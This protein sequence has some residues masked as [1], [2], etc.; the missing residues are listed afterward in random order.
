MDWSGVRREISQVRQ[1]RHAFF[2]SLIFSCLLFASLP[3]SEALA[4]GL[5]FKV[6]GEEVL[7]TPNIYTAFQDSKGYMWFGSDRGVIRFDGYTFSTFT[8]EQGLADDEVFQMFEDSNGRIWFETLNGKV[9]YFK[10]GIFWNSLSDTT[11]R[12]LDSQGI[13]AGISEDSLHNIWFVSRTE[14]VRYA[15]NRKAY[16]YSLDPRLGKLQNLTRNGRSVFTL[17]THSG[18]YKLNYDSTRDKFDVILRYNCDHGYGMTRKLQWLNEEEVVIKEVHGVH[19]LNTRTNTCKHGTSFKIDVTVLNIS[20]ADDHLWIGTSEG[21]LRYE[22]SGANK[23]LELEG[24]S[25]TSVMRDS[26]GNYWF[27]TYGNGIL[28]CTSMKVGA[29]GVKDG[30]LTDH[31]NF[32]TRDSRDRLWI[33]Y[34]AGSGG[35]ISYIFN[36]KIYHRKITT[37]P[38]LQKFKASA[39]DFVRGDTMVSTSVGTFFLNKGRKRLINGFF[40]TMREH[41]PGKLWVV[42]SQSL[43]VVEMRRWLNYLVADDEKTLEK[44]RIVQGPNPDSVGR[45]LELFQ[46]RV[47][48][49]SRVRCM[50]LDSM[51]TFWIGT[52]RQLYCQP[53]AERFTNKLTPVVLSFTTAVND[54]QQL[55]GGTLVIATDGDG[56][57]FVKNREQVMTLTTQSGM[58]SNVCTSIDI[59]KDGT[60]WVGTSNGVNKISGYP[61]A[62]QIDYLSVHDGLLSNNIDDLEIVR[63]TVW[64]ASQKG[65]SY[66]KN[67]YEIR[68]V[69][70]PIMYVER[71]TL[72]GEQVFPSNNESLVFTHRQNDIGIRYV[73]LLYG[74][75]DPLL[76]RYRLHD[77][78]PWRYTKSTSVYLPGLPPDSY[79]FTVAAQGRSGQWSNEARVTFKIEY[80]FWKSNTFIIGMIVLVLGVG[81]WSVRQYIKNQQI[82]MQRQQRVVLSELKT[83]RAQMNPHFLFNALN[84]I[85]GVLLRKDI[86]SVQEYLIRFGKLMRLILDHSDRA[87]ITIREEL[88]SIVNYLEIEQLRAGH[89][90]QYRIEF[91]SEVDVERSEIPA[92]ILQ[93]FI[94]N[95]IWHGF[96]HR[97]DGSEMLVIR[98][99]KQEEN[100]IISITDNGIGRKK[101]LTLRNREHK[102]KGIQLVKERIEILNFSNG[103]KIELKIEDLEDEQGNHPGTRVTVKIP[104]A[105]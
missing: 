58:S 79:Q 44:F 55:P 31:I 7:P 60:I 47:L 15:S 4:Q 43:H 23:K 81:G 50:M 26:E 20:K 11:L 86:E 19:V 70:T 69:T 92:M 57:A 41:S 32:L 96:G 59:E 77:T 5:N 37:E 40:R 101:A 10:D 28:F 91:D 82:E 2:I 12:G 88:D 68:K 104:I 65:L 72:D 67:D 45:G 98:F 18:V 54:I 30:L 73:G 27:T 53:L 74:N 66:V 99:S 1:W 97:K 93:P 36:K 87:S 3:G 64:I 38:V 103:R 22:P 34:G 90:F 89:Q 29:F 16:R 56:L 17:T 84:S 83:L 95:A 13:I 14:I 21:V 33:G 35:A 102:S 105:S 6:Y 46:S 75:G 39:I 100:I 24:M 76:Y 9:S 8:R 49:L 62:V 61:N 48:D 94:E 71:V 42:G 63:D 52:D 51:Q 85:Q 25:V 78:D 80:P